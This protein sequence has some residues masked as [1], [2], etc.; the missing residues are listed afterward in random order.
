MVSISCQTS[1]EKSQNT[2]EG[3]SRLERIK[4]KPY[5]NLEIPKVVENEIIKDI[6]NLL[7][8]GLISFDMQLFEKTSQGINEIEGKW[9]SLRLL[10]KDSYERWRSNKILSTLVA[11]QSLSQNALT[12]EIDSVYVVEI[13]HRSLTGTCRMI[14]KTAKPDST[15]VIGYT[16]RN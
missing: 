7:D 5:R 16:E 3:K 12:Q 13:E 14:F 4:D 2:S 10:K 1:S 9:E 6:L 8:Q 15:I 11:Y